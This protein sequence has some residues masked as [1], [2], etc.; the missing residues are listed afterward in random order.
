MCM[1]KLDIKD[2]YYSIPIRQFDQKYLKFDDRGK[3]YKYIVLPNG[4]R[5]GPRKFT[6]AMKP[7]LS[8]LRKDK[9]TLVDYIDDLIT[10]NSNFQVC[11][12]NVHK[13]VNTL[14]K[15][16]FIIHPGKS[17]FVPFKIMEFLGHIIDTISMTVT[18][19]KV[20]KDKLVDLCQEIY[21]DT[22]TTVRP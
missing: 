6:K 20:K 22:V 15:L 1:A 4:Y 7:P 10:M 9:V 19:A 16:G 18:I 3:L 8:E 13:I 11:L 5:E 21:A 17:I 2:A 12:D 14:D